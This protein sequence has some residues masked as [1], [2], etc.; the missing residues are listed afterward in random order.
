MRGHPVSR[1]NAPFFRFSTEA[2]RRPTGGGGKPQFFNLL[3]K[4]FC[5]FYRSCQLSN[6]QRR[7]IHLRHFSVQTADSPC[8]HS[9]SVRS[10]P[11][12][13]RLVSSIFERVLP[14]L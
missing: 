13:C 11:L 10:C 3:R 4:G 7:G 12:R 6:P 14:S 5:P 9:H 2:D 8:F 1:T